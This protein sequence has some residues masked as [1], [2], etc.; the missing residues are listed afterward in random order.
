MI[1][2]EIFWSFFQ[3]GLFS[4]G[5]GYAALPLIQEQVVDAKGWLTMTEFADV[6]TI[7]QMTPGPIA[8]NAATFVG[9]GVAGLPG[10]IVATLGSVTPSCIIVLTLAMVYYKYKELNWMKAILK[11]LKPAVIGLIASAGFSIL[12][13]SLWNGEVIDIV[14]IIIFIAALFVLRKWKMNPIHVMLGAGV[15]GFITYTVFGG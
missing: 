1:Y 3:I 14:A 9:I 10:A 2:L 6:I 13:F 8:L 7:S 4:F 5:G 15:V 11:G 12:L